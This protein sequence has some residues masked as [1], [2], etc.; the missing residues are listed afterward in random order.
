MKWEKY[1]SEINDEKI[2]K[3]NLIFKENLAVKY[4]LEETAEK[5]L[6]LDKEFCESVFKWTVGVNTDK[7]SALDNF[8]VPAA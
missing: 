6:A 4:T 1:L 7:E 3:N 5:T 2:E 8:K